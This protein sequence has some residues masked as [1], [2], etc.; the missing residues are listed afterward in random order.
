VRPLYIRQ[1]QSDLTGPVAREIEARLRAAREHFDE[2]RLIAAP[3]CGLAMLP[4]ALA[5][6]K[7]TNMV[8]AARAV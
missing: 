5:V 3:D 1:M 8:A 7:L 2:H 6:A 4:R